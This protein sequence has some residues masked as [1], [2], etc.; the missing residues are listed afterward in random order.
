MMQRGG[1]ASSEKKDKHDVQYVVAI[2]HANFKYDG[3]SSLMQKILFSQNLTFR[4]SGKRDISDE[5]VL[6]GHQ[7]GFF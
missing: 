7:I 1:V 6:K 5:S 3:I 4:N 2:K